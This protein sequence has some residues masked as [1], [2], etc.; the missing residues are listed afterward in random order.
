MSMNATN[1]PTILLRQTTANDF[2][3]TTQI[4]IYTTEDIQSE[5][6]LKK[7]ILQGCGLQLH[8]YYRLYR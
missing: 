8:R 3:M 4:E 2:D 5:E 7:F 6:E 1:I